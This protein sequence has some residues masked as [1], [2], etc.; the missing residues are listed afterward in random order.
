MPT[1]RLR[2]TVTET[3]QI[4]GAIDNAARLWPDAAENRALLVKRLVIIGGKALEHNEEERERVRAEEIRKG[5]G[6]ASGVFPPNARQ[7]LA[8]EEWYM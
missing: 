6:A 4:A 2:H 3:P 7:R 1:H 8:D 5:L